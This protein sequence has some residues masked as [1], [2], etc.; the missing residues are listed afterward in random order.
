LRMLFSGAPHV[1]RGGWKSVLSK[2]SELGQLRAELGR[3]WPKNQQSTRTQK[4]QHGRKR[5]FR[6][7]YSLSTEQTTPLG[8]EISHRKLARA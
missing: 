2:W 4:H 6:A 3:S 5:S 1:S 7:L 8:S